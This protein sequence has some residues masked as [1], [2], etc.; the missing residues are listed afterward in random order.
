M[1]KERKRDYEKIAKE[2]E[3]VYYL[4]S[5]VTKETIKHSKISKQDF[6]Y[7]IIANLLT[8]KKGTFEIREIETAL[9]ASCYAIATRSVNRMVEYGYIELIKGRKL[10]SKVGRKYATT[11][12]AIYLVRK[13]ND[14]MR[15][16]LKE[17]EL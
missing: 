14:T 13:Y 7:L 9:R 11:G 17:A 16:L 15:K 6:K 12:T 8:K 2:L 5:I 1:I 10:Y 3:R 4:Q